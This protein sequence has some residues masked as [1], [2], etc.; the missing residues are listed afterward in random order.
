MMTA[1]ILFSHGSTLCGAG[2]ALEEHA[3]RL[4]QEFALVEVGFMNYS[5]P[6]FEEAV[7]RVS[8]AGADVV[9]V[10]PFFLVPGYFVR[11]SLPARVE[12]AKDAY[13]HLTFKIAAP[14]GDDDL[15]VDALINAA[16]KPLGEDEWR[17][18]IMTASRSCRFSPECP[19]YQTELCPKTFKPEAVINGV[20]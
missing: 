13:P 9:T 19:I 14:L 2:D 17:Q 20:G 3:V 8:D 18:G 6:T 7:R 11:K 12:S 10:V 1:V 5:E 16:K 15:L 4:R